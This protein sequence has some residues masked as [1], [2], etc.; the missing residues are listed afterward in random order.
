MLIVGELINASRRG[1][2]E[3]VRGRDRD[4]II[5]LA[6]QQANSGAT[7]IDVNAGTLMDGEPEALEWLVQV[8][9]EE[10]DV[11]I[12]IDS[13]NPA[14]I[15]AALKVHQ[16]PALVN[17]ISAERER[18]ESIIPLVKQYDSLVVALCMGDT[19]IPHTTEERVS[20]ADEL[21]QELKRDGIPTENIYFDPLVQPISTSTDNGLIVLDAIHAIMRKYPEAHTIC[22]LSNISFGL[23]YRKLLNRDFLVMALARG[24][25]GVILDPLDSEIM[26][27]LHSSKV[28]L[29]RDE[30]CIGYISAFREGLLK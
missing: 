21:I 29:D 15:E 17:S 8:I 16:G 12:C 26:S 14:A 19:E 6:R 3:A 7:H 1:I 23:P 9:Q 27:A 5:D 20:I 28:L 25:D 18:Y 13:P 11:P 2:E 24:L 30:Y 4:F 22:G 10:M